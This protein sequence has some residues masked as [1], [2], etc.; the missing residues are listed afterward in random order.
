MDEKKVPLFSEIAETSPFI[1]MPE[2]DW[3][4]VTNDL[5][6]TTFNSG[7]IIYQQD[8][9]A[10]NIY[11]VKKGRI[12]VD[13]YNY[14]GE[15]KSLFIASTGC[16]FGEVSTIDGLPN[17]GTAVATI[18]SQVY[19]IPKAR[20]ELEMSSNI[21][22][23]NNVTLLLARKFRFLTA[24][25]GLQSFYN[26][27]YKVGFVLTH[28]IRSYGSKTDHGYRL[29]IGF[30]HQEMASLTGLSR[31]SVSKILSDFKSRGIIDKRNGSIFIPNI[32]ELYR[33]LLENVRT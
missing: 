4:S 3:S 28:L 20:F 15:F 5:E 18:S 10:N 25:V 6:Y 2:L 13:L 22:F 30:T 26:S 29:N 32:D 21:Q 16:L 24:E 8:T 31:V 17:R 12:R 14:T 33:V 23:C 27:Y 1:E 19:L 11:L 9:I 7:T